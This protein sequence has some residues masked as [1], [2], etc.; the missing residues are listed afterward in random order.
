MELHH[1]VA[2]RENDARVAGQ[3]AFDEGKTLADCPHRPHT[4]EADLWRR[5]FANAQFGAQMTKRP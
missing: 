4:R 5:S 3:R 1:L 2:Q